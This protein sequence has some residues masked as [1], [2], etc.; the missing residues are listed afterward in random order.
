M[1]V[2]TNIST[3]KRIAFRLAYHNINHFFS[4]NSTFVI[5]DPKTRLDADADGEKRHIPPALQKL[6]AYDVEMTKRFVSFSLNFVPIRS[7]KTNC[8]FL[9][10]RTRFAALFI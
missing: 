7:M 9:E 4:P 6:L 1:Q 5:M 3:Y 8:K 10:V 2:A